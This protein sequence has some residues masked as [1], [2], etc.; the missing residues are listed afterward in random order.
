MESLLQHLAVSFLNIINAAF[1]FRCVVR[2]LKLQNK[3]KI[4]NK[5]G[6]RATKFANKLNKISVKAAKKKNRLKLTLIFGYFSNILCIILSLK[7]AQIFIGNQCIFLINNLN[8]LKT[9]WM[10]IL[11]FK[12]YHS[13]KGRFNV[14][15]IKNKLC[16]FYFKINYPLSS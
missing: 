4:A 7:S 16:C 5:I 13:I 15:L 12:K 3:I 1:N 11:Y 6:N 9:K 2:Y 14:F 10:L 8:K